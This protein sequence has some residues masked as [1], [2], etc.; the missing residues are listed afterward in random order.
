V[1]I[2]LKQAVLACIFA[3]SRGVFSECVQRL[4]A[5]G[6]VSV[7]YASLHL[8]SAQTWG[9]FSHTYRQA[10]LNLCKPSMNE[11]LELIFDASVS[12]PSP[13]NRP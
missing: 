1:A 5:A 3:V 10:R 9:Q 13:A 8:M 4:V 2:P 6:W 12:K 7:E 11:L